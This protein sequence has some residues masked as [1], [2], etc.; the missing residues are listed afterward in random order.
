[1][2]ARATA[3]GSKHKGRARSG[4][5]FL[6]FSFVLLLVALWLGAAIG[7]TAIPLDV[8]AKTVANR[9]WSAGYALGPID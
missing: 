2:T 1:V 8:V 5:S 7:E 3:T 9:V 4:V 6:V